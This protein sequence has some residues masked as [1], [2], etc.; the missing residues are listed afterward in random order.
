MSGRSE[1]GEERSVRASVMVLIQVIS[2]KTQTCK[3]KLNFYRLK[4]CFSLV[5]IVI[6]LDCLSMIT[7]TCWVVTE[8]HDDNTKH[9]QHYHQFHTIRCLLISIHKVK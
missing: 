8:Q 9:L 1:W 3:K 4:C 2:P 5:M 6:F 7:L